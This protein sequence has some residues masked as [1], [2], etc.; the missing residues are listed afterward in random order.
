M[1]LLRDWSNSD[2]YDFGIEGGQKYLNHILTIKPDQKAELTSVRQFIHD[3]FEKVGC[4]LLPHPGKQAT[5]G[6]RR[7]ELKFD[8]RW[9]QVD[10][11][12]KEEMEKLIEFVLAPQNLVAKKINGIA[13][14]C[15]DFKKYM[16]N[17]FTL[18][19]SDELP[20]TQSIYESTVENH[21]NLL[22]TNCL[23]TYKKTVYRNEDLIT[24]VNMIN[25]VND[26]GKK[27]ALIDFNDA[28][29]MGNAEH[30]EKFKKILCDKIDD[31]F[32]LWSENS[33]KN[34]EKLVEERKKLQLA[35]EEQ[36]RL[37]KEQMEAEREASERL[38]V[39]E[40]ENA[41]NLRKAFEDLQK[42][43]I[44]AEKDL[45]ELEDKYEEAKKNND[46]SE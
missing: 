11:D 16:M 20:Q 42:V 32:Q 5:G 18:F 26:I 39:L 6:T 43:R 36:Q 1:V 37:E 38:A 10:A 3:S 13:V 19:A 46:E 33:E 8:G 34:I 15:S 24:T 35:L 29:K 23:Q 21:M 25:I 9:S 30:E 7:N 45:Q 4:A 14:K 28:R 2:Q 17:Y 44:N 27:E 31:L 40:A 12:F 22:V 41:K